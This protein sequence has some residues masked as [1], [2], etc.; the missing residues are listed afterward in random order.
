ME[1]IQIVELFWLRSEEAISE[2]ARKYGAYCRYIAFNI[3]QNAQDSE[4]C[5]NDTYLKAWEAM[6]PHRPTRLS[7]FLGKI[8]RR[9]SLNAL[10]HSTAQKRGA[11]QF[12]YAL[13]ELRECASSQPELE[14]MEDRELI[15]SVLNQSLSALSKRDRMVF[16]RRYWYF[17]PISEIAREYGLSQ[18]NVKT[19]LS[20]A[21]AKLKTAL[22]A[23]EINI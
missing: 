18:S 15:V 19:I 13:D 21:R 4:E 3:L 11:G 6:P 8:T 1:D 2:T 12:C 16:V 22:K 10:K 5:V 9:L 23:A 14:H 7:T 20:R 17:A